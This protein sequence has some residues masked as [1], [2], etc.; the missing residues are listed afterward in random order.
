MTSEHRLLIEPS[1]V[2]VI[3]LVC[4]KC[5]AGVSLKPS[6]RRHFVGDQCPNCNLYW[7]KSGSKIEHAT[8]ALFDAIQTLADMRQDAEVTV[9][10][11]VRTC[12]GQRDGAAGQGTSD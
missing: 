11:H 5:G 8:K 2:Q 12:Q 9:R 1:D 3:E 6:E 7:Y 10:L 4:K